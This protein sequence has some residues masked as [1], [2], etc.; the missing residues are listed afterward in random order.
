MKNYKGYSYLYT[1]FLALLC[2]ILVAFTIA[3]K[4]DTYSSMWATV[5][6]Y[7]IPVVGFILISACAVSEWYFTHNRRKKYKNTK[8]NGQKYDGTVLR[9]CE[10]VSEN[11]RQEDYSYSYVVTYNNGNCARVFETPIVTYIPDEKA[12]LL[13]GSENPV[14][15]D[16]YELED[17]QIAENFRLEKEV[18]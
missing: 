3:N 18:A 8:K 15:C 17:A 5:W 14:I 6:Y 4:Q 2:G 9:V 1:F 13:S 11:G 16:V 7:L 10:H 12:T